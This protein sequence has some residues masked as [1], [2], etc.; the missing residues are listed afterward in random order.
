[1]T[2]SVR[3]QVLGKAGLLSPSCAVT[4]LTLG[5][6]AAFRGWT[7]EKIASTPL[8]RHIGQN[9][10]KIAL[11]G[12][13]LTGPIPDSIGDYCVHLEWIYLSGNKGITGPIPE[14]WSNLRK[15][16]KIDLE[17][18]GISGPIPVNLFSGAT[19]LRSIELS[20]TQISG[21]IPPNIGQLTHLTRFIVM[22][23]PLSGKIPKTM[24]NL[25]K[26][27]HLDL[28]NTGIIQPEGATTMLHKTPDACS[29]FL[30]LL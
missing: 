27:Q 6:I 17:A 24:I 22:S 18:T 10:I 2:E 15:L 5:F 9:L 26:L 13:G 28:T 16:R 3:D 11:G 23:A 29:M 19:A 25:K 12:L 8:M 7:V 30:T 21:E 1:M 14:N 20:R 4:S